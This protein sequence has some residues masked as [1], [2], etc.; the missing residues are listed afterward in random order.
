MR[1]SGLF[2]FLLALGLA[3]GVVFLVNEWMN[4][5][6]DQ[7]SAREAALE[8][9]RRRLAAEQERLAAQQ[10]PDSDRLLVAA[11]DLAV[12]TK[13]DETAVKQREIT[14]E[15]RPRGAFSYADQA[16]GKVVRRE[17][18]EGEPILSADLELEEKLEN[19]TLIRGTSRCETAVGTDCR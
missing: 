6:Q 8:A 5:Q 18:A 9:E 10:Q 14:T 12:G 19:V 1:L 2:I 13:I 16:L 7:V 4:A 3:G 11:K 15:E 17:I